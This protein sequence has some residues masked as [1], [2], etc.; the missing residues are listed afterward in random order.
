M[1]DKILI[2]GEI[3]VLTGMH[4]GGG[5]E[6]SA[7][8][9]VDSPV[10]RDPLTRLP[11]IPGSSL[12]G[13]MRFLLA[14]ALS[15]TSV[16]KQPNQDPI[17]ILR[18]FGSSDKKNM[19]RSRL[20]F[21]DAF[22]QNAQEITSRGVALTE[23]KF[24]NTIDRRTGVANPR[25][26]ERVIKGSKFSFDL[27]YTLENPLELE[28]DLR[29]IKLAMGLLEL[30]YLGGHGTRGSGR[31]KFNH[32]QAVSNTGSNCNMEKINEILCV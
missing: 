26:I 8:G 27:F 5:N 6:F 31:I 11:I 24:E 23:I 13:K 4:I 17:E 20:K 2:T 16:L 19:V 9:A 32:I 18:L 22:Y 30:D 29:N 10:V 12:K 3:E 15:P 25:Q 1:I 21:N 7:I 28:E 14:K